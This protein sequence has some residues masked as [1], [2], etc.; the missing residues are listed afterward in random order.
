[1]PKRSCHCNTPQHL[2]QQIIHSFPSSVD[3]LALVHPL[4]CAPLWL[5]EVAAGTDVGVKA[6]G[7]G[8]QVCSSNSS[9]NSTKQSMMEAIENTAAAALAGAGAKHS[10]ALH[11]RSTSPWV[12]YMIIHTLLM[13]QSQISARHAPTAATPVPTR[14]VNASAGR[15]PGCVFLSR[16]MSYRA[17]P[18]QVEHSGACLALPSLCHLATGMHG[19]PHTDL[20]VSFSAFA[21]SAGR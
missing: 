8:T 12:P 19:S 16:T 9:S 1:M 17:V 10:S 2:L 21:S 13:P 4:Q 20:L 5:L 11:L 15:I 7:N 14:H 6:G 18:N 3:G